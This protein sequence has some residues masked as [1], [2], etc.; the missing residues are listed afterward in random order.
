MDS[1]K[2]ERYNDF[3]KQS[4]Y[5]EIEE[6]NFHNGLIEY[7]AVRYLT[8]LDKDLKILDVGCGPGVFMDNAKKLGFTNIIG[9]TMGEDDL[10]A[11]RKKGHI[12]I[13]Y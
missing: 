9:V 8:N 12:V 3:A 13:E 2:F 1:N 5:S 10:E 4:I 11:C 7:V 6:G